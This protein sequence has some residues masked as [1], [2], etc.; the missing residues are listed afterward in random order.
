MYAKFRYNSEDEDLERSKGAVYIQIYSYMPKGIKKGFLEDCK[1][2]LPSD[3]RFWK[4]LWNGKV[5]CVVDYDANSQIYPMAWRVA[6]IK[7]KETWCQ[8]L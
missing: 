4:D 2:V 7:K 3:A 1:R 8:F 5:L 6:Q